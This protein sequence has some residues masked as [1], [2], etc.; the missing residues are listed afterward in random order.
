MPRM[1]GCWR[2]DYSL[3]F[4]SR[5]VTVFMWVL[6]IHFTLP[7]EKKRVG[8]SREYCGSNII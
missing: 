5:R 2:D 8:F 6:V 7:I 1:T 3:C 4:D